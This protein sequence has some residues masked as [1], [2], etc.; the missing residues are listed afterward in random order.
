MTLMNHLKTRIKVKPINL[1][2]NSS[3]IKEIFNE[4]DLPINSIV[5]GVFNGKWGGNGPI[6]ESIDP[7][8]N[9]IISKIQSVHTFDFYFYC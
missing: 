8:T 1:S 5:P 6:I 4:L 2:A 7:A 3:A 9:K